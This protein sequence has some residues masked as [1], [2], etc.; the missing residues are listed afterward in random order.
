MVSQDYRILLVE[1]E[2]H[3]IATME[4]LLG[5]RYALRSARSV[6]EARLMLEEDWPDLL[7][8]DL[9]LP[10]EPGTVLLEEVRKR[11]LPL[12]VLVIT[13][14]KDVGT[15]VE[16]MR[17]GATDY[18][19]KPF[20]REDLLLRVQQAHE[21]WRLASEV[22]RLRTE[23]YDPFRFDSVVAESPQ[24][25]SVL[26]LARKM[27]KSEATALITGESGTGKELVARAIHCDGTRSTGPFVAVNCAQ[28][29]GTLLG[30]EL[31]GHEKGAFTGATDLHRGRFELA[32]GGTLFLDEVGNTSLEMQAQILRAVE[33]KQFERVGGQETIEVDVRVIAATNADLEEEVR[34]GGFR[35]DL[36]YRLNVVRI[37][38]PPL[39]EHR[40]DIPSLC[41]HFLARLCAKTGCRFQ[42]ITPE[43]MSVFMAYDWRGNVRELQNVLE[44]AVALEDGEWVTTRYLPAYMLARSVQMTEPDAKPKSALEAVV[45][46]FERS[47]LVEQ[48]RVHGWNHRETARCLGVH[49]NTIEN[50]IKKY[51]I[52]EDL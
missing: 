2:D 4:L 9:G 15:A 25:L 38:V 30:S 3:M 32:D 17:L 42:G 18:V 29:T 31:F 1:D 33:T 44:M 11:D 47:F 10:D 34:K 45:Q 51:C 50:K 52:R 22:T 35:E 8:L 24:M 41:K 28:F 48:L 19:Q 6:A 43:A 23:L 21:H 46:S 37:Q 40:Q 27:A 39:R 36:Y 16:V 12:D 5:E 14:W 26:A 7:L 49:R 13:A 20:D